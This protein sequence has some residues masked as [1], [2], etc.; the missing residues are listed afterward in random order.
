MKN[1]NLQ[2]LVILDTML[3]HG[4]KAA[5]YRLVDGSAMT[6]SNQDNINGVSVEC[7]VT[8]SHG[9][10]EDGRKYWKANYK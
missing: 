2:E 4:L 5:A 10:H 7:G 3:R 8:Y 9:P 1:L 6:P